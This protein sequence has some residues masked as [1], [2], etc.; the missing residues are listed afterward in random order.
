[1]LFL[2]K[3][4]IHV[5]CNGL[6]S[7]ALSALNQ[8]LRTRLSDGQL[9]MILRL[10]CHGNHISSNDG[11]QRIENKMKHN[12]THIIIMRDN[13]NAKFTDGGRILTTNSFCRAAFRIRKQGW[14]YRIVDNKRLAASY[15]ALNNIT[16]TTLMILP[17]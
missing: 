9:P 7:A 4:N 6:T 11:R 10:F 14:C 1:M 17:L 12:G 2:R 15:Y 13:N 3:Y 8:R 16:H 5:S